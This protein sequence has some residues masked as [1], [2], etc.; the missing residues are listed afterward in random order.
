MELEKAKRAYRLYAER[1][2]LKSSILTM[3]ARAKA[4][5]SGT[6]NLTI[7]TSWVPEIIAIAKR[8]LNKVDEEIT[9]L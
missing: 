3:E 8:E 6:T 2:N 1:D 9:Q 5:P 7:P 4:F